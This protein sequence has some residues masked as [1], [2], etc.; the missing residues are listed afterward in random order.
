MCQGFL[1]VLSSYSTQYLVANEQLSLNKGVEGREGSG[2][3]CMFVSDMMMMAT[4]FLG[5]AFFIVILQRTIKNL[6]SRLYRPHFA[7]KN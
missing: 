7:P 4:F 5:V 1:C 2:E 6:Q 3:E